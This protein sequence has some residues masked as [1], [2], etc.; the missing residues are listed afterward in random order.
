MGTTSADFEFLAALARAKME[1]D[2]V[3]AAFYAG[4]LGKT[5]AE[6]LEE[7]KHADFEF[8]AVSDPACTAVSHTVQL[9]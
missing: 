5:K 3:I 1:Q 9:D 7:L 8:S 4:S 2:V 6:R